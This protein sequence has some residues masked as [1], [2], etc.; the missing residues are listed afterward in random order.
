MEAAAREANAARLRDFG[1]ELQTV[2]TLRGFVHFETY[3][4]GKEELVVTVR[5]PSGG[6]ASARPLLLAG[7]HEP[8]SKKAHGTAA[9]VQ[10]SPAARNPE[11]VCRDAVFLVSCYATQARPVVWLRSGEA[12]APPAESDR[13][14]FLDTTD[15]WCDGEDVCCWEVVHELVRETLGPTAA[16]NPFAVDIACLEHMPP[17][18]RCVAAGALANF[19]WEV[20]SSTGHNSAPP[21]APFAAA[22]LADLRRLVQLHFVDLPALLSS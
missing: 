17:A 2:G 9:L 10:P 15:D 12:G 21:A 4:R 13:P 18:E 5:A 3:L 6:I 1:R 8:R 14:L 16:P 19:L 20:Y 22:L 11:L 7:R